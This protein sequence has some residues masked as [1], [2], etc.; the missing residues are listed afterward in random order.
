MI[1]GN[2]DKARQNLSTI[3]SLYG[4]DTKEYAALARM[5]DETA[6]KSRS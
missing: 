4:A 1:T 2:L 6:A 5:I 3:A